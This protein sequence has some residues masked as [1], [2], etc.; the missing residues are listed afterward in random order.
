MILSSISSNA[1]V[2][3]VVFVSWLYATSQIYG[4]RFVIQVFQVL[5]TVCD[6]VLYATEISIF[7]AA[8]TTQ[9]CSLISSR[10]SPLVSPILL[11]AIGLYVFSR[12]SS[13]IEVPH[14]RFLLINHLDC[15]SCVHAR[16]ELYATVH[17]GQAL[18]YFYHE[19][20]TLARTACRVRVY[21]LSKTSNGAERAKVDRRNFV[22]SSDVDARLKCRIS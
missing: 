18:E 3:F 15:T 6:F 13:K 4:H 19:R 17:T 1:F 8:T 7:F 22:G 12:L 5:H 16:T 10:F 11:R 9:F 21:A 20:K 2:R 14:R